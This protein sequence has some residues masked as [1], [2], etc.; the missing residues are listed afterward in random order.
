MSRK[1]FLTSPYPEQIKMKKYDYCKS[2][3]DTF[4]SLNLL[5]EGKLVFGATLSVGSAT[6]LMKDLNAASA[7]SAALTAAVVLFL[8]S[9]IIFLKPLVPFLSQAGKDGDEFSGNLF[10]FGAIALSSWESYKQAI[11]SK[12]VDSENY[13]ED[14]LEQI[15]TYAKILNEKFNFFQIG[16]VLYVL[17]LAAVALHFFF[18]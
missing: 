9:L 15:Y 10:F 2:T 12:F 17:G 16:I 7:G 5:A 8:V 14:V 13:A 6:F 11:E 4:Q 18:S 3:Y 1:V